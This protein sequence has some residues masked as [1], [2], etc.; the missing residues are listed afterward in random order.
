MKAWTPSE[1]LVLAKQRCVYCHGLGQRQRS[2]C[3]C[4]FR[5][6][7]SICHSRFLF[8]RAAFPKTSQ[9]SYRPKTGGRR[10]RPGVRYGFPHEEYVADFCLVSR[11]VLGP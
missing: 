6:I 10:F 9:A 1:V 8:C 4:V 5:K 11:R 2:V 3:G 7:F